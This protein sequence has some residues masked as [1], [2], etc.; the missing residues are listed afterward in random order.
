MKK[1]L[2][3]FVLPKRRTLPSVR[4]ACLTCVSWVVFAD[5]PGRVSCLPLVWVVFAARSCVGFA[6]CFS[7]ATKCVSVFCLSR[8]CCVSGCDGVVAC[9]V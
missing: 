8:S 2:C 5:V 4:W 1:M 9:P 6:S 7:V 3:R